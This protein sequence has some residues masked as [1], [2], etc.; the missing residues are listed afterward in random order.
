MKKTIMRSTVVKALMTEPLT[1]GTWILTDEADEAR[2][3]VLDSGGDYHAAHRAF[4][5]ALPKCSVCAVGAVMRAAKLDPDLAD[6]FVFNG[7]D[8]MA[9]VGPGCYRN[10][11]E[12]VRACED[13]LDADCNKLSVLSHFHESLAE[14]RGDKFTKR[15][16]NELVAFV[17]KYFPKRIVLDDGF[18]DD[19]RW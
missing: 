9:D 16:R 8:N 4:D 13:M 17:E 10:K 15:Y 3:E 18:D 1:A 11:K 19:D 12:L 6:N 2:R 7:N 5:T 14:M